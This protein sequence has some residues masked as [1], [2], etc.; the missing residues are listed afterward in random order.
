MGQ[1]DGYGG[2]RGN[3]GGGGGAGGD[4]SVEEL[5]CEET[6][7]QAGKVEKLHGQSKKQELGQTNG[8]VPMR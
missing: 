2:D 3:G 5:A 6:Q 4:G 8:T 1:G 7:D